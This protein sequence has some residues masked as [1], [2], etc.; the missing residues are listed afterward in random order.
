MSTYSELFV[1][2]VNT[3][4]NTGLLKHDKFV[5]VTLSI[6]KAQ[7]LISA[8]KNMDSNLLQHCKFNSI[9]CGCLFA[10]I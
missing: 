4:V 6:R 1:L 5:I 3:L 7:F 10:I 9:G 8:S 2:L